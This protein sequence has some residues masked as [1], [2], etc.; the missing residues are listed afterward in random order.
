MEQYMGA[1][2][3]IITGNRGQRGNRV[4]MES[5]KKVEPQ[6]VKMN[7]RIYSILGLSLSASHVIDAPGGLI[8]I[9]TGTGQDEGQRILEMIRTFSSRPIG[10]VIYTHSHY[11]AGTSALIGDRGSALIY[12][13]HLLEANRAETVSSIAPGKWL[14]ISAQSGLILPKEGEDADSAGT[15]VSRSGPDGY[16]PPNQTIDA[17]GT[18]ISILGVPFVFYT[19]YSFDTNDTLL[20]H[21]PEDDAVIHN[22]LSG[23]FPNIYS[24]GGGP[25]RDPV[26]WIAGLERILEIGPSLLLGVHGLPV[27]G[28]AAV[29]DIV[30]SNRDA[31]RYLYDQ[32]V[33]AINKGLTAMET[34]F[35]V[36]LPPELE[37]HPGL[38]QTYG[39]AWHHVLS[40]YSGLIGWYDG[41]P[42]ELLPIHPDEEARRMTES[43]GGVNRILD[44]ARSALAEGQYSWAARLLRYAHRGSSGEER[45]RAA[46]MLAA[47]LRGA[48]QVT[49]AWST[50]NV[51]LTA[52][53]ELE[54]RGNRKNLKTVPDRQALS[55]LGTENLLRLFRF[56]LDPARR[57][58]AS[59]SVLVWVKDAGAR[60]VFELSRGSLTIRPLPGDAL[61]TGVALKPGAASETAGGTAPEAENGAA[62]V[63]AAAAEKAGA[64]F[65]AEITMD[66]GVIIDLLLGE[67]EYSQAEA[68]GSVRVTG[69]RDLA[70]GFF[71][72]FEIGKEEP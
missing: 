64:G 32:T 14:R 2:V 48:G 17:D 47:A 31:I 5:R 72:L 36:R 22:H 71:S 26:P 18:K 70:R 50:R 67:K 69:D 57:P 45:G 25:Y 8:V 63:E 4:L 19:S 35:F 59:L 68:D 56:R 62:P 33:R 37:N 34:A 41:D 13:H 43:L 21:L 10:A 38:K 29:D 20:M 27:A 11:C 15:E 16:L 40:I 49:T 39:E 58:G 65:P 42:V 9:D 44:L 23:N 30:R 51:L 1:P 7:P 66:R 24:L 3:E 54:G 28:K 61:K 53:R 52:A 12:A 6:V 46:G 55:T 60:Y